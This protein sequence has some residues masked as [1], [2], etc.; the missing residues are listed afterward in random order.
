M[1][2]A[3]IWTIIVI[4]IVIIISIITTIINLELLPC[5]LLY[6]MSGLSS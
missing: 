3:I 5:I 1:I 2:G 6:D 4:I